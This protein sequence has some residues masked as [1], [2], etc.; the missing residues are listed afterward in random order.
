MSS[1]LAI[2]T[3]TERGSVAVGTPGA[4]LAEVIVGARRHAAALTPS[5]EEAL[6]L[7]GQSLPDLSGILIA[8]GPGSFTGLR[9]AFATV[10]GIVQQRP[11][12]TVMTA[13]SLLSAARIGSHFSAG[14]VAALYDALRGEVFAAVYAFAGDRVTTVFAPAL[15]TVRVLRE[16]GVPAALAVGDGA[17]TFAGEVRSWT[18]HEPVPPPEGGP[19]ASGLIELLRTPEMLRRVENVAS[20]APEYGRLAEA[21]VRWERE[22]GKPLPGSVGD[23]R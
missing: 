18:G 6:R 21:Q 22:H 23:R 4:I 11:D 7:A 10:Q 8:D 3:A 17:A 5:I 16:S 1:W 9:I 2:D 20:W 19:R 13:P 14:P 12:L 15:T